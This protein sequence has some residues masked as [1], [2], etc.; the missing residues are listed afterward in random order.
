[1]R[2]RASHPMS[3]L[4]QIRLK[5]ARKH[6]E[7]TMTCVHADKI[8]THACESSTF[9]LGTFRRS[10]PSEKLTPSRAADCPNLPSGGADLFGSAA[11]MCRS[12]R[13]I[14]ERAHYTETN[15]TTRR[16]KIMNFAGKKMPPHHITVMSCNNERTP[17]Q[18]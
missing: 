15:Q 13:I 8:H 7:D 5:P 3:R 16:S 10:S 2:R 18:T 4:T 14:S 6:R 17:F 11:E 1:M 9:C 12:R